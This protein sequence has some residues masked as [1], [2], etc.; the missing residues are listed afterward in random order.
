MKVDKELLQRVLSLLFPEQRKWIVRALV[1]T[2]LPMLSAPLWEPYLNAALAKYF[3]VSVPTPNATIGGILLALG[4][5]G[6]IANVVLDRRDKRIAVSQEDAADKETLTTLFSEL[7]LPTL[8]AFIEYGKTSM[9]YTPVLHYFFGVDAV[10]RASSYHLHDSALR[11]EV[12]RFH[13]A[14]TK[15]LSFGHYFVDMPNDKLQKF[16]SRCD[17]HADPQARKAHDE[18]LKAVWD[19]E[20]HI[21]ALCQAVRSKY[22]DFDLSVTNRRALADYRRH[23]E[24]VARE[25]SDWEL[26]VLAAVIELEEHR[27]VPTV[28]H[29]SMVLSKPSVDVRVA[30]DKLIDLDYVAH[31][32]PGM[33]WQ[34]FTALADGRAYYV[35]HREVAEQD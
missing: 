26:A 20:S 11:E 13:A 31:L 14:L 17:V 5:V 22:P 28:Q 2:G 21:K 29:L 9:V 35:S 15:A 6:G 7:H 24:R 18:F 19:A 30:L 4:I 10:V 3:E 1:I 8:D 33:P 23:E 27:Q 12:A 16:N 32:Y 25:V 34:K